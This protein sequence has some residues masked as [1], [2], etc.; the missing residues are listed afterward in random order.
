MRIKIKT[1]VNIAL[2]FGSCKCEIKLNLRDI[3][4]EIKSNAKT[5]EKETTRKWQKTLFT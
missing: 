3:Q 4:T 5:R 1:T 2:L